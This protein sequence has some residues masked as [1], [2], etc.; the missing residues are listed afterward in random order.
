MNIAIIQGAFFPVPPIMGGAVEKMWGRLGVEFAKQGHRVTHISRQHPEL[1]TVDEMDGVSHR[2]VEGYAQP[3]Q[4]WLLKWLDWLYTRRAVREVPEDAEVIVT[5]TF[6]A[7]LWLPG[8]MKKRAFVD[9]ARMPKGQCR[10][11]RQAG[12]LRANSTPVAEAIRRELRARDWPRVCMIPNPLPFDPPLRIDWRIKEPLLLY[13]GRVHPEKGL[14]LLVQAVEGMPDDWQVTMVGPWETTQ[15]GGGSSYLKHLQSLPTAQRIHFVGPV[16]EP[17]RLA[18]YYAR[19]SIFAYPSVAERGETFGLAPLEA[20]AW[21]AVP[22]VSDLACF[23][24]FIKHGQNGWVFD[25]RGPHAAHSLVSA[26]AQLRQ[27]ILVNNQ[28]GQAA[29]KVG[30]THA[31]TAIANTFLAEFSGLVRQNSIN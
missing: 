23:R 10:W 17:D 27:R 7:P 9:V 15:G 24:D 28:L 30:E 13:C 4:L 3:S 8:R 20:M 12:R 31:P 1:P 18:E 29:A 19:A 26:I 16:F 5:N 6:W 11:Y 21:G 2:R 25:H 14:D 22:V